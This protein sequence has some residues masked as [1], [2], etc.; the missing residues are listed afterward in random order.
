VGLSTAPDGSVI[1]RSGGPSA[2]L[3]AIGP[4]RRGDL[5]E[6]TAIPEI[7]RQASDLAPLIL[8]RIHQTHHEPGARALKEIGA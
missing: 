6:S 4:L 5:W 2:W 8:D 3:T 1:E 7:A